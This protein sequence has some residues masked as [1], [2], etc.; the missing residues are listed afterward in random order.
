[1]ST[2]LCFLRTPSLILCML[3]FQF[4]PGVGFLSI[5]LL[6]ICTFSLQFYPLICFSKQLQ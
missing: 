5:S 1:M 6:I 4:C 2:R 3:S